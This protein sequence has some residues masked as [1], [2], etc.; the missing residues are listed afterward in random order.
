MTRGQANVIRAFSIWTVYVWVTRMWNIAQDDQ[1]VGF[2]VVHAT[3][4]VI[5]VA[6]A[7]VVWFIVSRVRRRQLAR[8][9]EAT[10]AEAVGAGRP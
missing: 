7:V 1:S 6:F 3:L 10:E 9:A 2:K 8:E 5:S 4:A